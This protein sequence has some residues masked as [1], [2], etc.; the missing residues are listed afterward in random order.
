MRLPAISEVLLHYPY[1]KQQEVGRF[2]GLA[3]FAYTTPSLVF[4]TLLKIE[5]V[6]VSFWTWPC[7]PTFSAALQISSLLLQSTTKAWTV[8]PSLSHSA[9]VS[10]TPCC[11]RQKRQTRMRNCTLSACC[12]SGTTADRLE[13]GDLSWLHNR[14]PSPWTVH[15]YPG[16]EL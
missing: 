9:A 11:K 7:C 6:R 4:L 2:Q 15:G 13:A 10:S 12:C 14:L 1:R 16:K 8:A 3:R 5:R